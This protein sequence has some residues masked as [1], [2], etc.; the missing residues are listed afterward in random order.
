MEFIIWHYTIGLK[1]YIKRWFYVMGGI[2]HFFSLPLLIASL[3]SP[4]HR[5]LDSEHIVGINLQVWFRQFSFNI[6][7]RFIGAF[8]RISLFIFGSLLLIPVSLV[9]F[10]GFIFWIAVPPI[11]LVYYLFQ[12]PNSERQINNLVKDIKKNSNQSL[13]SFIDSSAGKY[14]CSRLNLKQED[15]YS[16]RL[17]D[18]NSVGSLTANSL[19]QITH[20]FIENE[21]WDRQKLRQLG[22]DVADILLTARRWDVL[23]HAGEGINK[24]TKYG[25]PGIGLELLFGYTPTLNKYGT[26]LSVSQSFSSHLI[27]RKEIV[28]RIERS[29][30]T[31][32]SV[33]LVGQSGVGKKT[34]VLEFAQKCLTGELGKKMA[35]KR[36]VELDYNFLL[37]K[38]LDLSQK[39]ESL[40]FILEES[41]SSG[42]V[43]LVIK[44]L[45]RLTNYDLEGLDFTDVFEKHL[46]S[47]KLSLIAISDPVS[48]ERFIASNSR[49]RKYLDIVDAQPA[50]NAEATEI[51]ISFSQYIENT[52][53][54]IIT[55]Q[56]IRGIIE[57]SD[58]YISDT[59]FPEKALELLDHSIAYTEKSGSQILN[60]D[61]VNKVLAERTGISMARLTES[62][63]SKLSDLESILHKRLIGQDEAISLISKSLRSRAVGAKSSDKPL[64][65]FLFLGPTGVGKTETAKTLAELYFGDEKNI[66]RYDM[67]EYAGG[68]G[69][70]R[71]IGSAT[72]KQPGS[73]TTSIKNHPASLLLLDEIEKS[74]QEVFNLFLSLLD[75]GSITDAMGTKINCKHLFVIATSNAG[76]EFIKESLDSENLSKLVL[77]YVQK[78]RLFSPEFLNRFDGVVVFR[79]LNESQLK[80]I[81]SIQLGKLSNEMAKQGV[82]VS[83]SDSAIDQVV[84]L[85]YEPEFGARPLKRVIDME[86]GDL[87]ARSILSGQV[88]SGDR[89]EISSDSE[90]YFQINK[91]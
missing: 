17:V 3:F 50:T 73:L 9:G 49:L 65:S 70:I 13:Q 76:A 81:A 12:D 45:H 59:P 83:F 21:Y 79:P 66:I 85:G 32:R 52:K 31:S 54:I 11:G 82:S 23:H 78:N 74:P 5:L 56:A 2:V 84:K 10:I 48:Y 35:Y 53:K 27:A 30:S 29:I 20:F 16:S 34:I 36:V 44:D 77:E 47:G 39:K 90:K 33:I 18:S 46:E 37:S 57:G 25:R 40:S 75:E 51:I 6:I 22:V 42:N 26:D 24:P 14:L 19:V 80:E 67:A 64:G 91:K 88:L 60:I 7:S 86:I 63:K 43:I 58:K 62:E 55:S 69:L 8:V 41:A 28:S 4:Y 87:I 89:I 68:E 72:T 38:N 71:L 61:D 15:L 1:T